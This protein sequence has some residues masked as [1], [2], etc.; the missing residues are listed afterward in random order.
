MGVQTRNSSS[1]LATKEQFSCGKCLKNAGCQSR[2]PHKKPQM[3]GKRAQG[4]LG[5]RLHVSTDGQMSSWEKGFVKQ[6]QQNQVGERY[7]TSEKACPNY[8]DGWNFTNLNSLLPACPSL[9]S[10]GVSCTISKNFVMQSMYVK[11]MH[12]CNDMNH[13]KK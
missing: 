11:Q 9:T 10:I 7:R 2:K 4:R 5:I 1:L 6:K 12:Q 13:A 3:E 8:E